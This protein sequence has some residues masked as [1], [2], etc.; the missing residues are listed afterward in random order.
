MTWGIILRMWRYQIIKEENTFLFP[1]IGIVF[2]NFLSFK[3][4]YFILYGRK[5][6]FVIYNNFPKVWI[7]KG[8]PGSVVS[9]VWAFSSA[10]VQSGL[11]RVDTTLSEWLRRRGKRPSYSTVVSRTPNAFVSWHVLSVTLI[12]I[13]N[14]AMMRC[15][16]PFTPLSCWNRRFYFTLL[17]VYL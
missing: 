7:N 16:A 1:C 5:L 17:F 3:Q 11:Q 2:P 10:V 9:L 13:P 6:L 4:G 15:I 14:V 8:F 12:F